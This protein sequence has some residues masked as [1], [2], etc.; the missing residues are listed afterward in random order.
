[1]RFA[2]TA[3]TIARCNAEDKDLTDL[4]LMNIKKVTRYRKDGT[5]ELEKM[6]EK[7][8][9]AAKSEP[10]LEVHDV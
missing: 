7:M 10:K 9:I 1:M 6:V 2:M 4:T 8:R 3:K 5:S